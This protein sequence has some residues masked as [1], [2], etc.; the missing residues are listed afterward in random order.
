MRGTCLIS[1][2]ESVE[3]NHC[4]RIQWL[5]ASHS[6]LDQHL[7]YGSTSPCLYMPSDTYMYTT[8]TSLSSLN[9]C[10]VKSG[11]NDGQA[12]DVP[13]T[14]MKSAKHSLV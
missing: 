8:A 14:H 7:E 12:S 13:Y 3:A 6:L 2:M 11:E 10:V 4:G 1:S 5:H 9:A